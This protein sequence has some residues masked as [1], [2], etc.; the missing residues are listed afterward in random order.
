M[1]L[2]LDDRYAPITSEFGFIH[3][4]CEP[5]A[6]W[7]LRRDAA[8]HS[9][10]GVS[11]DC[12]QVSG[13]MEQLLASLLPLTKV[14]R[15]RV[16]LVPTRASGWSAVFDSGWQGGDAAALSVAALELACQSVRVVAVPEIIGPDGPR[17]YGARIFELY[18]PENTEFLNYVRTISVANDGGRWRFD[19]SGTPLEFED[20]KWFSPRTIRERF[21]EEHLALLL[22]RMGLNAFEESFYGTHARLLERHGPTANGYEELE[23]SE[24]QAQWLR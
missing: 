9:R 14:E 16:L 1:R 20:A 15:R 11:V 3:A 4:P 10:R 5:L 19:Q 6:E 22:R 21:Q 8:I 24:V 18:G 12:R 2:L 17:R 23:L 7:W 13:T